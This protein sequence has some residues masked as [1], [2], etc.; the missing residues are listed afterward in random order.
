M[1]AQFRTDGMG[2]YDQAIQAIVVIAVAEAWAGIIRDPEVAGGPTK[3]FNADIVIY[4][5]IYI[6]CISYIK[7]TLYYIMMY[8]LYILVSLKCSD[9]YCLCVRVPFVAV[10][11]AYIY[12]YI[13]FFS[14]Y[15]LY[16]HKHT[17]SMIMRVISNDSLM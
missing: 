13:F 14:L 5:Y 8:Y 7:C 10:R 15:I 2:G 16:I 4:V 17:A 6:I 1:R 3:S 11:G 12:I 9:R